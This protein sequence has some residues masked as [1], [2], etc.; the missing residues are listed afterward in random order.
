MQWTK[1]IKLFYAKCMISLSSSVKMTIF[2]VFFER[3]YKMILSSQM[4]IS[5]FFLFYRCLSF[6]HFIYSIYLSLFFILFFYESLALSL[7]SILLSFPFCI[8]Y[9]QPETKVKNSQRWREREKKDRA[10]V[11][12]L[13]FSSKQRAVWRHTF[14]FFSPSFTS[15]KNIYVLSSSFA[16]V[17]FVLLILVRRSYTIMKATRIKPRYPFIP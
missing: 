17:P 4:R 14:L 15:S 16:G 6:F 11:F 10:T 9:T 12:L 1:F 3:L 13:S 2:S 7:I 5:S 8:F